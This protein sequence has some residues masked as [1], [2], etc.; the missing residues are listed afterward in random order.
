MTESNQVGSK[1]T[2]KEHHR[3]TSNHLV[4][5]IFSSQTN[6]GYDLYEIQP[7]IPLKKKNIATK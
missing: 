6:E 5:N 1:N 4:P 7:Y 3:F 2:Q